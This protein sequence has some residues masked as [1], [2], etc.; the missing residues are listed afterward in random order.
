[1]LVAWRFG[2]RGKENRLKTFATPQNWWISIACFFMWITGKGNIIIIIIGVYFVFLFCFFFEVESPRSTCCYGFVCVREK[3]CLTELDK[4]LW[5]TLRTSVVTDLSALPSLGAWWPLCKRPCLQYPSFIWYKGTWTFSLYHSLT[6]LWCTWLADFH[7]EVSP[8][9]GCHSPAQPVKTHN[10]D[11]TDWI[12]LPV[13]CVCMFMCWQY[14][15]KD[16]H[17]QQWQGKRTSVLHGAML[18]CIFK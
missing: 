18:Y 14:V 9:F 10:I 17:G 5:T 3:S 6:D 4:L 2:F 1:M 13:L 16:I 11:F 15:L 8:T 7:W 12:T